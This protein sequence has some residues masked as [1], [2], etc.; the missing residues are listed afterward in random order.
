MPSGASL[1]VEVDGDVRNQRLPAE[2]QEKLRIV[3]GTRRGIDDVA[4][5]AAVFAGA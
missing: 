2:L 3:E 1:L 5:D 4:V